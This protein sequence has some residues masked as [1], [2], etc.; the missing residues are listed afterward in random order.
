MTYKFD[1]IVKRSI[2]LWELNTLFLRNQMAP[3]IPRYCCLV[4][5]VG[6][7]EVVNLF[8]ATFYSRYFFTSF[9][10]TTLSFKAAMFQGHHI[11]CTTAI[12]HLG[13]SRRTIFRS[14]VPPVQNDLSE[15]LESKNLSSFVLFLIL[16]SP[17]FSLTKS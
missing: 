8:C 1:Q 10:V 3:S 13:H 5:G 16:G 15:A 17:F 11:F 12:A 6:D 7:K 4:D 2:A 9:G 14:Q